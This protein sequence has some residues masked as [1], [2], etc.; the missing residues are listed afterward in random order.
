MV[1]NCTEG[2]FHSP[3]TMRE[4]IESENGDHSCSNQIFNACYAREVSSAFV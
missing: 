2:R 4:G 3:E 1:R